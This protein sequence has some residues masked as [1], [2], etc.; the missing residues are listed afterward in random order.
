MM[1]LRT[2]RGVGESVRRRLLAD[3][4]FDIRGRVE[5]DGEFLLFPITEPVYI[6]GAEVI[7]RDGKRRTLRPR[8]LSDTLGGTLTEDELR[9]LPTSYNVVGDIAILE[10]G[11]AL[12]PRRR[13]IGEALLA[14]FPAIKV[15]AVK[16]EQVQGE[17]RVP[18]V[19]VVAGEARSETMHREHGCVY[20]LDVAKAYFTPRLGSERM[21]VVSQIRDTERVLVMFAGVGPYAILAAKKTNAE[22]TAVE[23]NPD[24]VRYMRWNVLK[25]RVNVN[26]IEGD[27]RAVVP[28]LGHFD[29]IIMPLPKLADTFLDVAAAALKPH[30]IIHYYSFAHNTLEATGYLAETVGALGKRAIILAVVPCGS[31]SPCMERYCVDFKLE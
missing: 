21:R 30:G 29:R 17:Y 8:S 10:L 15:A 18:K 27:V 25:N 12:M 9:E 20:R 31:Y 16:V 11:E 1:Y 14:T 23:L 19:Q 6:E 7:E 26:V 24:A 2:P 13:E 5:K 3:G 4:V 28:T 22:V